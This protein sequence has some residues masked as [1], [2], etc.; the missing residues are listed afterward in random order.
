MSVRTYWQVH[1]DVFVVMVVDDVVLVF[2]NDV[3]STEHIKRI[4]D[5][6]LN[7]L[8]I[9]LLACLKMVNCQSHLH[10]RSLCKAPE[11]R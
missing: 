10:R 11:S 5:A 7:I 8:K 2:A 1:R 4:I 6:S 9:D 3:H